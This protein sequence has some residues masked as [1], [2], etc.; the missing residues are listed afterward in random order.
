MQPGPTEIVLW[1]HRSLKL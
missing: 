1:Q